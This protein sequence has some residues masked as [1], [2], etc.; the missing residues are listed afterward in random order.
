MRGLP[1]DEATSHL[2]ESLRSHDAF[3]PAD[4]IE[5]LARQL[6]D[7][8]WAVRHPVR[9]VRDARTRSRAA[10]DEA[11]R[12]QAEAER[13]HRQFRGVTADQNLEALSISSRRTMDGAVHVIRVRPWSDEIA[14]HLAQ[15]AQPIAVTVE[16]E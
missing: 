9:A 15:L 14:S 16:R 12:C 13:L 2:E 10:D 8:W 6:A 4:M 11:A 1:V 5:P 7:P 3:L